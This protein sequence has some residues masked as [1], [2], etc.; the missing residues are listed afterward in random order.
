[1]PA[2]ATAWLR[3]CFALSTLIEEFN[4]NQKI[5]NDKIFCSNSKSFISSCKLL[6]V[7]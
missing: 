1:M 5:L 2:F 4:R 6:Q 7:I 3:L